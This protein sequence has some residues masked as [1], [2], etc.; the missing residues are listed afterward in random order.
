MIHFQT[1]RNF[2]LGQARANEGGS[3]AKIRTIWSH[4]VIYFEKKFGWIKS[5]AT[6]IRVMWPPPTN[7]EVDQKFCTP[8]IPMGIWPLVYGSLIGWSTR[9]FLWIFYENLFLRLKLF[10]FRK[11]FSKDKKMLF[12]QKIQSYGP[13][14][15]DFREFS[16]ICK[17]NWER[18]WYFINNV[19]FNSKIVIFN[20]R[21]NRNEQN[22][23]VHNSTSLIE[24][25][26]ILLEYIFIPI[27][28]KRNFA[29]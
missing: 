25:R 2:A 16:I 27:G 20:Q 26:L 21:T 1:D 12:R 22:G 14:T 15:N 28:W 19:L 6:C 10:W 17:L 8:V 18:V 13:D 7:Y 29:I 5:E 11:W 4:G 23:T 3:K 24:H 9:D